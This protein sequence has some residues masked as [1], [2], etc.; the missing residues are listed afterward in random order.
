MYYWRIVTNPNLGTYREM[1]KAFSL[2]NGAFGQI[3]VHKNAIKYT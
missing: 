1:R 2:P 3:W